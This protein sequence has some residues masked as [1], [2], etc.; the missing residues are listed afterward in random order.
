MSKT[1]PGVRYAEVER[2]TKE[3][4]VQVVL[5]LDGGTRRDI[6]TGVGFFDHMLAQ[7]AFH[8][9]FD[10]GI[11]AEGDLEIDDHHTVE[12]VG[13]V[14]G[15]A[16]KQALDHDSS[17]ARYADT[18]TVMDEALVLVAIDISGRGMLCYDVEFKRDA[19]GELST[20]CVREFLRAFSTHSG[21]TLH[22]RKLAGENDHHIC[23]A[24]FKG[25][26]RALYEATRK[27][28]RRGSASTKGTID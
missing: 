26:G 25:L 22:V 1:A 5:D 6:L 28:D 12:D 18:A 21:I 8:G 24:L 9:Q 10:V 4:R 19:I 23:E 15:Q 17:I 27:I 7:L 20:E 13:I 14:L 3:T 2:E 11:S 16:I